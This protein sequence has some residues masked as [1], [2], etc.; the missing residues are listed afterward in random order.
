[1]KLIPC[2]LAVLAAFTFASAP[3][4]A[5]GG[6]ICKTAGPRPVE[7][8]LGFGHVPSPDGQY[9]PAEAT[10]FWMRDTE[11]RL[12][13]VSTDAMTEEAVLSAQWSEDTRSYD[14][15]LWRPGTKRWVR[16]REG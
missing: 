6:L 15:S 7:V 13:L 2:L 1:M 14:G 9:V 12:A 8:V 16:C 3:A 5:T 10:Q 11:L 4:H